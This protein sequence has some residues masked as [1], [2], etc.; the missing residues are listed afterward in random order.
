MDDKTKDEFIQLFNQ[1]FEEIIQP[2]L[3][4]I[5]KELVSKADKSD[6]DRLERK[7]DRIIDK[8]I[9]QEKR[10]DR[11]ESIPAIAHEVRLKK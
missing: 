11:I 6:I 8:D 9:V 7:M 3:E 5:R 2:E 1:G 10:L 4:E